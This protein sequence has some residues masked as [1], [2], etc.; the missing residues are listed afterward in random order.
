MLIPKSE[1]CCPIMDD[2]FRTVVDIIFGGT[3][4]DSFVFVFWSDLFFIPAVLLSM[5]NIFH[6]KTYPIPHIVVMV[7]FLAIGIYFL[8]RE[9]IAVPDGV[10]AS[11]AVSHWQWI[12]PQMVWTYPR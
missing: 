7:V 5:W 3:H 4:S 2:F 11:R 1:R 9:I 6:K 10:D 8:Y 12:P